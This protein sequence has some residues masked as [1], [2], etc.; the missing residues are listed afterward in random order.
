VLLRGLR[1]RRIQVG[2][3]KLASFVV[4]GRVFATEAADRG[5]GRYVDHLIAVLVASGREVVVLVPPP[6]AHARTWA[7]GVRVQ[8][9]MLDDDPMLSTVAINRCLAQSG[10]ALYVDA[11]PFLPPARYDVHVCPVIAVLF[12]LIPMKFPNDYFPSPGM[13]ALDAYVNGLARVQKADHVI[14]ISEYV[15]GDALR[16]LGVGR[17]RCTVITPALGARYARFARDAS[18]A[19]AL[20]ANGGV[21]CIQGAHRSK[22]FPAAI[23]F[24]ERLARA[25]TCTVDVVAPTPTQRG[26][27][28]GVRDRAVHQVRVV[29]SVSEDRKFSLQ[30][31]ARAIA[32]LSLDEGYGI[33]LAE[34][35][36]LF[37]P[38]VCLDIPINREIIADCGEPTAAGLFLLQDPTLASDADLAAAANFVQLGP[39]ADW[40]ASRRR[41]VEALLRRDAEAQDRL[42][43]AFRA[44]IL[45]F[46]AWHSRA[47]IG[48]VAPTEV[49]TCGVSDYSLALLRGGAP[50]YA[51][52]LGRAPR[53]LELSRALRLLPIALLDDVRS[54]APRML[55][56]LAVSDS[57]VRAFD[58]IA[59][60]SR[61]ED[62]LVV[63][64]AG[65][66]LPGLLMHA[67]GSGDHRPLDE[68]YLRD[69]PIE[70]RDLSREWLAFPHHD[71]VR[72]N[73]LF[74]KIDRAFCSRW[75]R[76][77]RGRL[78]SH[79]VAFST[80]TDD[81]SRLP[82]AMLA[83]ESEI[84]RRARYAPMP[85]DVRAN[86]AAARFAGKMRWALGLAHQDLL[87]CCAGSIVHGKHLDV[88]ARVVSTLHATKVSRAAG[89]VAL[90]LAGRVLDAG[91]FSTIHAT[92]A[93]HGASRQLV[94][95]VEANET[96]YDAL[97]LAS[98]VVVAFREQR[99]IQMSH[100]YVRALALGR[101]IITNEGAGF[102][103]LDS[104]LVC[105]DGDLALDLERH[106]RGLCD[107]R[108][109][110]LRLSIASQS[111]YRARHR[112][113]TF[114]NELSVRAHVA[115]ALQDH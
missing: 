92:F 16:Y 9:L 76:R 26:L 36:C 37:R 39:R 58:A 60:R 77:F 75:L 62:V 29:D 94:Q 78:V 48:I 85:I 23:P 91:L 113:D 110:R 54:R 22:N 11:T 61:D 71:S 57:L 95:I 32:H 65:S 12:D 24:L 103:D 18:V 44:A 69:E 10:A 89:S 34:A 59:E 13:G 79:H 88:V 63:H 1:D 73:T 68:R 38:V 50:R 72:S 31:N 49:G 102:D 21:T 114:F 2:V 81:R 41:I 6:C 87:V 15:R 93:E 109:S 7:A 106:L 17:D 4:D 82:L 80:E 19:K 108:P 53:E 35:I 27:I 107:D 84:L 70:V 66:Y 64:D 43:V 99:R 56:N 83:R 115:A 28:D 105:R 8:T 86:P 52:I 51:V 100:S 30:R 55:F 25:A 40:I 74:L 90:M 47:G 98:D 112:V 33:P 101:P 67:A 20:S 3:V 14:A 97:L 45:H 46:E 104:A 111:R 42:A 96:R 5:M